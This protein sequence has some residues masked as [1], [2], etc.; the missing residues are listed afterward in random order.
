[1]STSGRLTRRSIILGSMFHVKHPNG[2]V[3]SCSEGTLHEA[4][5]MVL[6]DRGPRAGSINSLWRLC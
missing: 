1:M 6:L 3:E 5:R 2:P 4:D